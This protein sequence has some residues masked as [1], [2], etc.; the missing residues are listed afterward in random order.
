MSHRL[1]RE[2]DCDDRWSLIKIKENRESKAILLKG[3]KICLEDKKELAIK[4]TRE[5]ISFVIKSIL[6]GTIYGFRGR[7]TKAN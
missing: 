1:V 2:Y 7:I 4:E 6:K 3:K 5:G